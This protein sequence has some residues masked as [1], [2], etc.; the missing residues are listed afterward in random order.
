VTTPDEATS[1][2]QAPGATEPAAAPADVLAQAASIGAINAGPAPTPDR[3][4]QPSA[5]TT[6]IGA[7]SAVHASTAQAMSAGSAP[8][9]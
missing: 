5:P 3:D 6:H 4:G 2:G 1:A 7:E 8:A 9:D